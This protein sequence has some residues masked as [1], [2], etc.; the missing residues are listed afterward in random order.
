MGGLVYPDIDIRLEAAISRG[1]LAVLEEKLIV[2]DI[3]NGILASHLASIPV[4]NESQTNINIMGIECVDQAFGIVMAAKPSVQLSPGQS[5]PLSFRL[6]FSKVSV[7]VLK[8]RLKYTT[9]DQSPAI[10]Y[11]R[12]VI[13]QLDLRDQ[14]EPHKFT[15]L[16]PSNTIS[17]AILRPPSQ[18]AT[19]TAAAN[20]AWPVVVNLHGAGLEADSD[21]V[22]RMFDNAPDLRG[23]IVSPTGMTSWSSDDWRMHMLPGWNGIDLPRSRLNR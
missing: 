15:F 23:W 1:S 8:F 10:S 9:D 3:V 18:L 19:L 4:R 16:H 13:Y 17:Y 7:T 11:T 6:A 12:V 5:R 20:V 2:P 22:R 14:R 21:Q